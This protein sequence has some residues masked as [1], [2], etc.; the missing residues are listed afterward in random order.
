MRLLHPST[1]D[2]AGS[3]SRSSFPRHARRGGLT[4]THSSF[5]VRLRIY[6][7]LIPSGLTLLACSEGN[8]P[9]VPTKYLLTASKGTSAVTTT[10]AVCDTILVTAQL[11][12]ADNHPVGKVNQLVTW[13]FTPGTDAHFISDASGTDNQ[14]TTANYFIFGRTANISERIGVTDQNRLQGDLPAIT[15]TADPPCQ[16]EPDTTSQDDL[17]IQASGKPGS[18]TT[19]VGATIPILSLWP[20]VSARKVTSRLRARDL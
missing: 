7:T 16:P 2:V 6:A 5:R 10:A 13:Y 12:D 20:T 15:V 18:L 3:R 4:R 17:V 14:G 19:S 1:Y 11:V 9:L 8:A